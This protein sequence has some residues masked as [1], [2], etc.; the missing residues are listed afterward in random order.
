MFDMAKEQ[1]KADRIPRYAEPE[2]DNEYPERGACWNCDHMAEV[3]I[4][5]KVYSLC[6][7]DRDV[8]ASG[9]VSLIDPQLR[10][11]ADWEDYE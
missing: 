11:C 2:F 7:L 5:K 9:D 3:R 1:A 6:V 4:G 10:D 8:S